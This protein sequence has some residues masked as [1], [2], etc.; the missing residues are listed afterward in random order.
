MRKHLS[1]F[2]TLIICLGMTSCSTVKPVSGREASPQSDFVLED[3][4]LVN[5]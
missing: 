1:I 2:F 5:Y 3:A 4:T